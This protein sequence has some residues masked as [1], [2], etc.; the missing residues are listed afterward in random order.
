[1][2][3]VVTS[4]DDVKVVVRE[5]NGGNRA[6]VNAPIAPSLI[7]VQ[8]QAPTPTATVVV[9]GPQGPRGAVG[10]G[11]RFNGYFATV[12]ELPATGVDGDA[13]LVGSDLYVWDGGA[14]KNYGP[15]RGPVGPQGPT[16]LQ[17]EVG[18]QGP[19][20]ERGPVGETGPMGPQGEQGAIGPLGPTG[21]R[22]PQGEQGAI[23]PIGPTGLRGETGLQG[24][25][26]PQGEAGAG[27]EVNGELATTADLPATGVS[28]DAYIIGGSLWVWSPAINGWSNI[29]LIAGPQGPVGKIGPVGPQ[30]PRGN[31]GP[32]GPIGGV[33]IQGPIGPQGPRGAIGPAGPPGPS[34]EV[35]ASLYD[36]WILEGNTGT[37][38]DYLA[39]VTGPR[40]PIGP[41][42]PRGNSGNPGP[43]GPPG[44]PG[45]A[46]HIT[47]KVN[48]PSELPTTPNAQD[49][50]VVGPDIYV[51]SG[52]QWINVGP[53]TGPEGPP[54]PQ[55]IQG[56][57][58]PTGPAGPQGLE[59]PE[60]PPGAQGPR[61]PQGIQ[62]PAGPVGLTGSQGPTGPTGPSGSSA[63]QVAVAGGFVG[64]EAEWLNSLVGPIGPIG[65]TGPAGPGVTTYI[66]PTDPG[67]QTAAALWIKTGVTD[68]SPSIF[69]W[70][71]GV[72]E[73][74]ANL[75]T[76]TSTP[77]AS[78]NPFENATFYINPESA[79]K[80]D[81]DLYRTPYPDVAA[82]FDKIANAPVAI[83]AGDW[84][85]LGTEAAWISERLPPAGQLPAFVLYNIPVRDAG[86]YSG[87]G[88]TSAAAYRT[89]IDNIITGL[90]SRKAV[91]FYEPDAL[92]H[93]NS[94]SAEHRTERVALMKE[95]I[96]KLATAGH[97]VYTDAGH[98][99]WH[100][101]A[102][103][104][105]M[106]L[107]VEAFKGRGIV[108]NVSNFRLTSETETFGNAIIATAGLESLRM[109]IDTSRNGNGPEP[110]N[111]VFNPP[112]RALGNLPSVG[113]GNVDAYFYIK[114]PGESDGD[115]GVAVDGP[116]LP[117]RAGEWYRNYGYG[118]AYRA[119]FGVTAGPPP[120][121]PQLWYKTNTLTYDFSALNTSKFPGTAG[122]TIV[123]GMGEVVPTASY[124]RFSTGTTAEVV[125][126]SLTE[127][128]VHV[129][130][131]E[132]TPAGA[133]TL[134][135]TLQLEMP[136]PA[137]GTNSLEILKQ[138][139]SLIAR[140]LVAGVGYDTDVSV[141]YDAIAHRWWR[142][143]HAAGIVYWE[144]SPD[145]V[146]WTIIRQGAPDAGL[147]LTAVSVAMVAGFYGTE[148][149]VGR[150]LFD[151][152]NL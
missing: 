72:W 100:P 7:V 28:G 37:V 52:T 95:T 21:P 93:L 114:A 118:L 81:A 97:Y 147:D 65:P 112:G 135:T 64:T 26:G 92:G 98:S 120:P 128:H 75:K 123:S 61:G 126:Y 33:G 20:G 106:L 80:K 24:P 58:G 36:L 25:M 9:P 131:P 113:T 12:A 19:V 109:V 41:Q 17:G 44:P 85:P 67:T 48:T 3:V 140:Q 70:H 71:G 101:A 103:W 116:T 119:A 43:V 2:G 69:A 51:W 142:I 105:N 86:G 27:I 6:V 107:E 82:Q 16:G 79:A 78:S 121:P 137:G 141:A 59:G 148:T 4:G 115:D 62:G 94:L 146:T 91:L 133:G 130:V 87:G 136:G 31:P 14:W 139:T 132:V 50:Y 15:I 35:G 8:Q 39:T 11:L 124:P 22:G 1:M 138:G 40:G 149:T 5:V 49:A 108:L 76:D 10:A 53:V 99:N 47:G 29:G 83:W 74:I 104:A 45:S 54:G 56:L 117:P 34:G 143:R 13:W 66:Q 63:Y 84:I 127:S 111:D 145:K 88:A 90:G 32:P 38:E 73:S 152:L 122:G 77:V 89:W 57:T 102:T 110:N 55:G 18:P 60:G 42:G 23:G 125:K 151:N 150:A 129:E 46:V 96:A 134:S 68:A 144:A 30:G